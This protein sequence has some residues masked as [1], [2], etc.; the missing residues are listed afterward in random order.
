MRD[1]SVATTNVEHVSAW[2][3]HARDFKRHVICS[4]NFASSSCALEASFDRGS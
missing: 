2:W 4:T 3:Q 1:E